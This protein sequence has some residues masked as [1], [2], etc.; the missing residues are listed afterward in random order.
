MSSCRDIS[1]VLPSLESL[2]VNSAKNVTPA[3]IVTWR[4]RSCD[5][6]LVCYW[7]STRI[8]TVSRSVS[9]IWI[10]KDSEVTTFILCHVTSSVTWPFSS[11]KLHGLLRGVNPPRRP[12][13]RLPVLFGLAY[14]T[15][16]FLQTMHAS[17]ERCYNACSWYIR[18]NFKQNIALF[19]AI[20][21]CATLF[22]DASSLT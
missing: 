6:C 18:C 15:C 20:S 2:L 14:K 5:R 1:C 12:G 21:D 22:V 11:Q 17:R 19:C 13:R 8:N 3:Y 10:L 7:W 9:E 16:I 4:H